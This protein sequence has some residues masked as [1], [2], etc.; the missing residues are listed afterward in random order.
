MC[1]KTRFL[2]LSQPKRRVIIQMFEYD[3]HNNDRWLGPFF[4]P[5][6]VVFWWYAAHIL[7]SESS[8][9]GMGETIH[10]SYTNVY[11]AHYRPF[12]WSWYVLYLAQ[13]VGTE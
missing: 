4:F 12:W 1:E 9:V 11:S 3:D 13:Y 7:E 6:S 2:S 8:N 5:H 10:L